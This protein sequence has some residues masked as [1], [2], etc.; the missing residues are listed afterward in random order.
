MSGGDGVAI[1]KWPSLTIVKFFVLLFY[2][3]IDSLM[4]CVVKMHHQIFK[5]KHY[6]L[7]RLAISS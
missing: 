5:F 2:I 7:F 3:I 4:D 1:Q 6:S